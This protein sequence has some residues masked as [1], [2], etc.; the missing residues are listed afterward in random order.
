MCIRDSITTFR[1]KVAVVLN[2][3][4]DHTD[5]HGSFE[6][7][8]ADKARITENQTAGDVFMP[9]IEDPIAAKMVKGTRATTVPFSA[10]RIP[11]GGIGVTSGK[12][13]WRDLEIFTTDD[14]A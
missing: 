11:E 4:E 7:Y 6:A 2:V 5:W 1:P 14:S 10:T 9:N 12:V 3:A 13:M 8:A